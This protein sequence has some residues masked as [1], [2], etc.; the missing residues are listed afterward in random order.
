MVKPIVLP[1]RQPIR[2]YSS[3]GEAYNPL[4]LYGPTGTGKTHLIQA[5]GSEALKQ[6]RCRKV[7]F[8]TGEQFY[9]ITSAVLKKIM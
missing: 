2:W 8:L 7:I 4:F 6:D 9:K 5:I 1:I 3:I